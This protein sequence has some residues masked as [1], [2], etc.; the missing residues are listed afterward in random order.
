MGGLGLASR[1]VPLAT[2]RLQRLGTNAPAAGLPSRPRGENA[3]QTLLAA[4]FER[5]F[6]L[7]ERS[8]ERRFAALTSE[9]DRHALF[10]R[11][12]N[13]GLGVTMLHGPI[14]DHHRRYTSLSHALRKI[15]YRVS[16]ISLR[17]DPF[18][19]F[20]ELGGEGRRAISPRERA[21]DDD[22]AMLHAGEQQRVSRERRGLD[23]RR[24]RGGHERARRGRVGFRFGALR[25]LWQCIDERFQ[26]LR[27]ALGRE[28]GR[29]R[30]LEG[31]LL[32][33][34]SYELRLYRAPVTFE[35]KLDA[36]HTLD[37]ARTSRRE[38]ARDTLQHFGDGRRSIVHVRRF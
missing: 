15:A 10:T 27:C 34:V 23:F 25:L 11:L 8:G 3:K 4:L 16:A 26:E 38:R 30:L 6:D 12:R 7:S 13:D 20:G 31:V 29:R 18:D 17:V 9:R 32:R 22:A 28:R 33:E 24:V 37:Q 14:E 19:V 1:S 35:R 21:D 2:G 5:R 36:L